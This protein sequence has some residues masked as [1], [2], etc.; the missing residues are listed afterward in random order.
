MWRPW[1]CNPSRIFPS[2]IFFLLTAQFAVQQPVP[3]VSP[4]LHNHAQE[5]IYLEQ[6]KPDLA[7]PEVEKAVKLAAN[8]A[9]AKELLQRL[10]KSKPTGGEK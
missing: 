10:E 3:P 8:Y 1:V 6:K 9:E 4:Q 7:R 5:S 2:G